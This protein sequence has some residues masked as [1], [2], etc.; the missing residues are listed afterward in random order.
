[1]PRRTKH[2]IATD[3]GLELAK[4]VEALAEGRTAREDDAAE[5]LS[6]AGTALIIRAHEIRTAEGRA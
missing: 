2:Q 3:T 1:M 4:I 5:V 6:A